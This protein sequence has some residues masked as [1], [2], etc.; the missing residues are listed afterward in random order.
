MNV[1]KWKPKSEVQVKSI[2]NVLNTFFI[3]QW[4]FDKNKKKNMEPNS[5]Y[6]RD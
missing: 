2:D 6:N 5:G 4:S 1:V 3:N